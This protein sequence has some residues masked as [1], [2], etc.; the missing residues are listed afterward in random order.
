MLVISKGKQTHFNE[1]TM[2]EEIVHCKAIPMRAGLM[3]T[4]LS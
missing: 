2:M 3:T 1:V 4:V